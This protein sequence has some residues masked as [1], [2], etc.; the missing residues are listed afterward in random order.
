M[1]NAHDDHKGATTPQSAPAS[2]SHTPRN[3]LIALA[4]IVGL[5]AVAVGVSLSRSSKATAFSTPALPAGYSPVDY[6]KSS[7]WLNLPKTATHK[8]DVFY[9]SDTAYTQPTPSSPKIG[10]INAP[11]MISGD[12]AAFQ[13]TAMAFAPVANIY[14]P[15]YRQVSVA[16][17]ASMTGA[18]QIKMVGGIPTTDAITAFEYYLKHYNNGRPFILAGHSQGSSVLTHLLAVYMK[19]NPQVYKRMV[20]AYVIGYPVTQTYLNQSPFLKFAQ[21]ANDTGV[22]I[23]YNTEASVVPEVNPVMLGQQHALVINPIT[24]TRS[25]APA[26]AAQNLGSW[27]PESST[28]PWVKVM[29]FAD[30]QVNTAKGVLISSSPP[31]AKFSPSP[32][33]EGVYHG[34]DYAFYFFNI[35][36]NAQTRVNHYFE[37]QK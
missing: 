23:S 33:L 31:V 17:Q 34:F 5:G 10:P 19:A 6:S 7:T 28:G 8:I 36:E 14:A 13:R 15:Y 21:G 37:N 3:A 2:H 26:S 29:N 20:A 24:W 22:I 12:Q 4:V 16:V 9:L 18:Q 27:L 30:A 32:S 35:Q 1:S 11:S 25:E